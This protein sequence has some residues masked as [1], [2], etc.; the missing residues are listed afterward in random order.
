MTDL[1]YSIYDR[2]G[3]RFDY[4][5]DETTSYWLT[6]N[7]ESD[8]IHVECNTGEKTNP[9]KLVAVY[10]KPSRYVVEPLA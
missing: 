3:D 1:M 4:C 10:F 6:Y 5:E 7:K 9:V 2:N 8:T